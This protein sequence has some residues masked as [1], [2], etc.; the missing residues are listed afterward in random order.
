MAEAHP[1]SFLSPALPCTPIHSRN[2]TAAGL[3][4]EQGMHLAPSFPVPVGPCAKEE[5]AAWW[6]SGERAQHW[7]LH[8]LHKEG[9]LQA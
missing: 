8:G 9:L 1:C 4:G 5:L 3:C 7:S 6:R 2:T